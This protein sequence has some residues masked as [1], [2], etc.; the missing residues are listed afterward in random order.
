MSGRDLSVGAAAF[1]PNPGAGTFTPGANALP[2]TPASDSSNFNGGSRSPVD[3]RDEDEFDPNT[4]FPRFSQCQCCNGY[5]YNC[6]CIQ[7]QQACGCY[8][9]E[10]HDE[11]QREFYAQQPADDEMALK[12]TW[13]PFAKDCGCCK[14]FT[15]NCEC[16]AKTCEKCAHLKP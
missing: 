3:P 6:Q 1:V 4:F 8:T 11:E 15:Y 13:F 9:T 10:M 12:E 7:M 5:V 16:G 2:I 14:G